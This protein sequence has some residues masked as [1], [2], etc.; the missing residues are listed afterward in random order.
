MTIEDGPTIRTFR[1][2]DAT[3]LLSLIGR[4]IDACYPPHYVAEVVTFFKDYH[5]E[6]ALVHDA[7]LGHT[8]VLERAGRL[9]GT[10][11]LLGDEVR[12]VFVDPACQKQGLG[13]LLMRKLEQQAASRGIGAVRLDASLPA[14]AFYEDLGYVIFEESVLEV[15]NGK[16]LRYYKMQKRLKSKV[17]G[18]QMNITIEKMTDE[19]WP[20]VVAILTEGIATGHARFEDTIPTWEQFDAMHLPQCRL[21]AKSGEGIVGWFVLSSISS[22]DV[23]RG[24]AEVSVYIKAS[25]RSLGIGKILLKAGIDASE[26]AGFWTLQ[27]GIFPENTAS[28]TLHE[29]CGFRV[30]GY[31]E[32]LGQMH[33]HWRDVVLMERRSKTVGV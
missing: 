3:D 6:Q 28:L 8:V 18:E 31:R 11:T 19:D 10:G 25:T 13:R 21:V 20:A 32:R 7:E 17:H 2:T 24:V 12:R 1:Q 16:K 9:V 15:A 29:R 27:S 4:T 14:V 5:D 23:Y 33:G 22:R 26:Q 30:V